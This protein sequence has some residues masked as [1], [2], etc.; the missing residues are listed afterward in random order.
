MTL[1]LPAGN[2][3]SIIDQALPDVEIWYGLKK[4]IDSN[5][6]FG[7]YLWDISDQTGL[8]GDR[9]S[10]IIRENAQGMMRIEGGHCRPLY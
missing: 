9:V 4:L 7:M 8:D 1:C 3:S 10:K 2:V 6:G 5:G